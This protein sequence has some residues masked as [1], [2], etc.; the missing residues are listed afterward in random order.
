M[1]V[2]IQH[3]RLSRACT[4][5]CVSHMA[6]CRERT[7]DRAYP[8]WQTVVS[9]QGIVRIPHC[10]LSGVCTG[11]CVSHMADTIATVHMYSYWLDYFTLHEQKK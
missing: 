9:V 5:L 3:D 7:R 2:C 11:S 4:G 8:T 10:R 6:D 1:I